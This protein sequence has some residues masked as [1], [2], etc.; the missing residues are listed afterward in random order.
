MDYKARRQA[1]LPYI[2]DAEMLK[3]Q[4]ICRAKL[5]DFNACPFDDKAR[6]ESLIRSIF[7][8]VG[9]NPWVN[10]PFRCDYGYNIEVGDDFICN[11]NCVMLDVTRIVIG[12]RVQ[13]APN[14][15]LSTAGHPV[16][17]ETRATQFEYGKPITIGDDVWLG[18]N[19]V[20]N[21]GISI[22]S[23]AVIGSGSIVT[24]DIPPMV[25]AAGNPCRILRNIT[26]SDRYTYYKQ[27]VF[28][29]PLQ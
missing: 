7:G 20:V 11:Y 22:G 4:S 3:E 17:P 8:R 15:T 16:H 23:G 24:R 29:I 25:I 18:A 21:P 2:C 14:V 13:I 9:K 19:V 27:E 26:E 28:D 6:M 12:D 10:A 5:A 1:G